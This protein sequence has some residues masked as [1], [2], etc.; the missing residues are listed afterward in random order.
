[1]ESG[2]G[3]YLRSRK[4]LTARHSGEFRPGSKEN[5]HF[6]AQRLIKVIFDLLLESAQVSGWRTEDQVAARDKT[7]DL[8]Q[9]KSLEVAAQ[10]CH[11]HETT[12]HIDCAQKGKKLGRGGERHFRRVQ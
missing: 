8:L 11:R 7:F 12:A 9:A 2:R 5:L 6:V 4:R 10:C 1:M 3:S